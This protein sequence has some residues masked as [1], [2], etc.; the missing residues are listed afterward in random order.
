MISVESPLYMEN[1]G[2]GMNFLIDTVTV[3][4]RGEICTRPHKRRLTFLT[5]C[6]ILYLQPVD[7]TN[8][9]SVVIFQ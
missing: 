5:F 3:V 7:N 9:C 8:E 1:I 4:C 2:I 6:M